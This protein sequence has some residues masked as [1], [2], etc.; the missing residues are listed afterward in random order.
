MKKSTFFASVTAFLLCTPAIS[1][2]K[3]AKAPATTQTTTTGQVVI[4]INGVPQIIQL[5]SSPAILKK[6]LKN[7]AEDMNKKGAN[8]NAASK[9]QTSKQQSSSGKISYHTIIVGPDGIVK[10]EKVEK[11]I[12]GGV[13]NNK[14]ILK[15]L[16]EQVRK[17]VEAAMKQAGQ[18]GVL[19]MKIEADKLPAMIPNKIEIMP[20]LKNAGADLPADV[21][22]QLMKAMQGI[23]TSGMQVGNVQARA[24]VIGPDGKKQEYNFGS[25][26]NSAPN[27]KTIK[28]VSKESGTTKTDKKVLETLSK[29][30]DRLEKLENELETL[31]KVNE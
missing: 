4:E 14:Q 13:L 27:T 1:D 17:Q 8:T 3:D 21:R 19:Q 20:L 18:N 7:I 31:K 24:I 11:N 2:D 29:I 28:P 6:Q 10:E 26:K 30:L 12:D 23:D 16:P 5:D 22:K 25:D 9:K 15:G